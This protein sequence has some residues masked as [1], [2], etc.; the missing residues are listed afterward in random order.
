MKRK[1][2]TATGQQPESTAQPLTGT[3]VLDLS[4]GPSGAIATMLLADLGARVLRAVSAEAPLFREQGFL[5]WDR[6]KEAIALDLATPSGREAVDALIPGLDVLIHDLQPSSPFSSLFVSNRLRS[7]NPH[8]VSC[9]VTA[10]GMQGPMRDSPADDDLVLARTGMLAGIPGFRGT[11]THLSHRIPSVAAALCACTGI[12]AS[13]YM[14]ELNGHGRQLHT[15]LMAAALIYQSKVTG[16]G[17]GPQVF[18]RHPQGTDPFLGACYES[19]DGRYIVIGC[20]RPDLV[21]LCAAMLDLKELVQQPRYKDGRGSSEAADDELRTAIAE[22]FRKKPSCWWVAKLLEADIPHAIVRSDEE[23]FDDPQVI[24]NRSLCTLDD[25]ARGQVTQMG[26]LARFFRTPAAPIRP[27]SGAVAPAPELPPVRYELT[28]DAAGGDLPLHG[29][30]LLEVSNLVAG[31]TAGRLLAELGADIIKLEPEL[32]DLARQ[33]SGRTYFHHLNARK[34]SICLDTRKPDGKEAL[35]R[36]VAQCDGLLANIRPG[37][38]ERMG[39]GPSWNADLVESHITAFGWDGPYASRPGLDPMAQ[40]LTGHLMA[41]GGE[42]NPPSSLNLTG[43]TDYTA[44][45]IC[46]F[47]MTLGLYMKRRHGVAQRIETS[48]LDSAILLNSAWCCR[49]E[50]KPARPIAD[51]GQHGTSDFHRL[52]QLQDGWIYLAADTDTPKAAL[53]E[54]LGLN[55]FDTLGNPRV[56]ARANALENAFREKALSPTLAALDSRS[57]PAAEVISGR[58]EAFFNDRLAIENNTVQTSQ[59]PSVGTVRFLKGFVQFPDVEPTAIQ[60]F[61]LLGEHT[62]PILV[63]AG[64]TP[65]EIEALRRSQTAMFA[66]DVQTAPDAETAPAGIA[67]G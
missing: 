34:R 49:Y 22:A 60:P 4:T 10:F 61:P 57:I 50:G 47:N 44:G 23:I 19:S 15:S 27:R 65:P 53:L 48:L 26:R 43:P 21:G 54:W 56:A 51:Q 64:L 46:A 20:M 32:G 39:I 38:T 11:P 29:T 14:R 41:Q 62:H 67:D 40:A 24:H 6:G 1:D 36:I 16:A 17:I 28:D 9:A 5:I 42:G 63:Q 25:P 18:Q 13:L 8:L 45:L 31:P 55:Q 35:R 3:V 52:Y 2:E 59:H 30:R 58:S 12:T 33:I 37:A 7:L 66:P